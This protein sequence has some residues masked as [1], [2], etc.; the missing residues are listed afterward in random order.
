[1]LEVDKVRLCNCKKPNYY[2]LK[3]RTFGIFDN[4]LNCGDCLGQIS[5]STLPVDI[6]I[7]NWQRHHG[8]TFL[9]Y[10]ESD[11]FEAKALKELKNYGKGILNKEGEKI[12]K[13]L[14]GCLRK[15]VYYMFFTPDESPD[16]LCPICTA[17]G[18]LT[19]H[20]RPY[21]ICRKCYSAFGVREILR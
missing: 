10:F 12:R 17:K 13:Q 16:S 20:S 3:G 8:R 4:E 1:M 14:A 18:Q 7:E 19:G 9:N 11:F 21:K 2:F 6:E 5:Y 15:P